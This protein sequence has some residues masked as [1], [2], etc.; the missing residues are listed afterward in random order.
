MRA[1][2]TSAYKQ[3]DFELPRALRNEFVKGLKA[4][5]LEGGA[6]AKRFADG[7]ACGIYCLQDHL[8]SMAGEMLCKFGTGAPCVDLLLAGHGDDVNAFRPS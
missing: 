3:Y 5:N 2:R 6:G 8:D 7:A 4:L 1:D